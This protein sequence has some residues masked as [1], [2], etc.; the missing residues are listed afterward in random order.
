VNPS[1]SRGRGSEFGLDLR[2]QGCG[3][4]PDV[5]TRLHMRRGLLFAFW[6]LS[7]SFLVIRTF[8]RGASADFG[9]WKRCGDKCERKCTRDLST[10]ENQSQ[11]CVNFLD[12]G[13]VVALPLLI[14]SGSSDSLKTKTQ[15]IP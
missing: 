15:L 5:A 7:Q 12:R 9:R 13:W 8:A 11:A 6:L 3:S 2:F 1:S 10:E 14:A 4:T